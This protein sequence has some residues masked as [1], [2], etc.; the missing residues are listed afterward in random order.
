MDLDPFSLYLYFGIL[1]NNPRTRHGGLV[2]WENHETIE[3][4]PAMFD[5]TRGSMT[6]GWLVVFS[7]PSEKMMEFV[8]WDDEIPK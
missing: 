3:D 6:Y 5:D 1:W 4:F 7:Y 8:S 2:R